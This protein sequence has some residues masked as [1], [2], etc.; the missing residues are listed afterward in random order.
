MGHQ[1]KDAQVKRLFG[2]DKEVEEPGDLQAGRLYFFPTFFTQKS[3]EI[4]NP[5]DRQRR[6]GKNPILIESVPIG[7]DGVFT[8]LYLPFNS[9]VDKDKKSLAEQ[10]TED[11][12]LVAEALQKMLCEYGFG[13]K[14]SSGFGLVKD[15]L[16]ALKSGAKNGYIELNYPDQTDSINKIPQPGPS[17]EPESVKQI[18]ASY[19]DEDFSFKPDEWREKRKASNSQRDIYKKARAALGDYK[20][21]LEDYQTKLAK[22]EAQKNISPAATTCREF[23]TLGELVA[24]AKRLGQPS[25][26]EGQNG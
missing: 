10:V 8:L 5:H 19:P 1:S 24:T 21:A 13:A 3:L 23:N 17:N 6:V 22:Y 12:K 14:T 26:K 20:K 4:I 11:L 15:D 25:N 18:R 2:N 9:Q 7:A 16:K